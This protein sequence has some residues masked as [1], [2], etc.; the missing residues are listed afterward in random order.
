MNW[1][2]RKTLVVIRLKDKTI[3]QGTCVLC[4]TI[5]KTIKPKGKKG[6]WPKYC[7]DCSKLSI[8]QR[9]RRFGFKRLGG[10]KCHNCGI[11]DIDLLQFGHK[12]GNGNV[13]RRLIGKDC[14]RT[15]IQSRHLHYWLVTTT[16]EEIKKWGV[17]VE[18]AMCNQFH[19]LKGRY[20]TKEERSLWSW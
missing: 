7:P 5:F 13:H 1:G 6:S 11:E 2:K 16:D 3:I 17:V 4:E 15:K 8:N 20:P 10:A 19:A 14:D 12:N 18:C 9:A